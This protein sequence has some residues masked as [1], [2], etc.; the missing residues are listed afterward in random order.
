MELEKTKNTFLF[1]T[2]NLQQKI[3]I[4]KKSAALM[5]KHPMYCSIFFLF[6]FLQMHPIEPQSKSKYPFH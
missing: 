6:F 3:S 2:V 4:A 1:K 5:T